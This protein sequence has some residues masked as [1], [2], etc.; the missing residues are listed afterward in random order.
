MKLI[1]PLRAALLALVLIE[2]S[3]CAVT[4]LQTAGLVAADGRA[5]FLP[6]KYAGQELGHGVSLVVDPRATVDIKDGRHKLTIEPFYRLDP[7]DDK[8][9]H[10]D[11]REASYR[12][13][14]KGWKVGIGAGIFSWGVLESYRPTDVI[15]QTDFV[16]SVDGTQKLGQPYAEVGWAGDKV[17]V[18]AWYLPYF[19][20][21]TYQGVKGRP[22]GPSVVNT[23][24]AQFE[25]SL[26]QWQPSGAVRVAVHHRG[27]DLGIG[28]FS[29]L[30]REPRFILQLSDLRVAPR[31]ELSQR[32]SADFQ[33]SYKGFSLKA[34]GFFCLYGKDLIRFGGGGA[35]VDYTFSDFYKGADL[36]LAAELLF[37]TRGDDLPIT[38]FRHNAFAGLRLAVNDS[39][40]TEVTLGAVVDILDATT[41]GRFEAKRRF[42][43]HWQVAANVNLFFGQQGTIPGSFN[44]DHYAQLRI[45]YLF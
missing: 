20:E 14:M 5:F 19:R 24:A 41:W 18:T 28:L 12:F 26:A 33:W 22:R 34:E 36:T 8:R 1:H 32:A 16:E 10:A 25:T 37:D 27:V 13:S 30:S 3:A 38:F 29:G 31:Y 4:K 15:N 40:N 45:A 17:S 6:P 7:V 35:G 23:E 42:G 2:A 11:L 44:R 21:R 9:S 43:E 39:G